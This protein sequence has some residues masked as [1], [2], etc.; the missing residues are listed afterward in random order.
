MLLLAFLIMY[1]LLQERNILGSVKTSLESHLQDTVATGDTDAVLTVAPYP[2]SPSTLSQRSISKLAVESKSLK[3][4]YRDE[5]SSSTATA[6]GTALAEGEES[7]SVP[8]KVVLERKPKTAL[9][10]PYYSDA[11]KESIRQEVAG[12]GPRPFLSWN[13]GTPLPCPLL[14]RVWRNT[15]KTSSN[16]G[17]PAV[18]TGILYTKVEKTASTTATSVTLRI[19][20]RIKEKQH[21]D[22]F[23]SKWASEVDMMCGNQ[24]AHGPA[25]WRKY[26]QR[27]P[28]QSVLWSVVRDPTL[29][30]VSSFFHLEV[31][32][33]GT[34]STDH[35]FK[36]YL[37]KNRNSLTGYQLRYLSLKDRHE[38]MFDGDMVSQLLDG[39][40]FVGVSER[41][42]E[43]V[44]VLQMLLGLEPVDVMY[45]SSKKA[46]GFDDGHSAAKCVTIQRSFVSENMKAFFRSQE[47]QKIVYWDRV[48]HQVIN[49]S[50]DLTIERLGSNFE[51]NLTE[52]RRLQRLVQEQ[53]DGKVKFPCMKRGRPLRKNET[54]CIHNDWGCGFDCIDEV[55]SVAG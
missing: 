24:A 3:V 5:L 4:S 46:G 11:M 54:D 29:R 14:E 18:P 36:Q 42:D 21:K 32:R 40:D 12:I 43:S 33:K 48:L 28:M 30:A 37:K 55:L 9:R 15:L 39:Y 52:F 31:S 17:V 45:M 22:Q 27:D 19:A 1:S 8:S 41:M 7:V 2:T 20:T 26:G 13:P 51:R 10:E 38:G 47:W 35:R 49:Q 6:N 53:C 34:P 44:V 16:Q 25:R 23:G 50:L